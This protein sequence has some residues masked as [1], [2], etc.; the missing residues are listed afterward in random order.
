MASMTAPENGNFDDSETMGR[1]I[2]MVIPMKREFGVALD[3][4]HFLHDFTYAKEVL[5][6]AC[7]SQDSRLLEHANYMQTKMFGPR[8]SSAN[9]QATVQATVPPAVAEKPEQTEA[10]MRAAL[11]RKYKTGLR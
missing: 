7:T 10:D 9:L 4:P 1:A 8:N 6:V 2:R 3:V 5:D 11:M